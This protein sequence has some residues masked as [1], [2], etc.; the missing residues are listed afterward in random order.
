MPEDVE[1]NGSEET[2]VITV[3]YDTRELY[4]KVS[5]QRKFTITRKEG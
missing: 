3:L 5:A 1:L 2:F 4:G